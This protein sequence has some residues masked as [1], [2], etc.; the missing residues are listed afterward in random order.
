MPTERIGYRR[1]YDAIGCSLADCQEFEV[2]F[3]VG[4]DLGV[5]I[6]LGP[7]PKFGITVIRGDKYVV[8]GEQSLMLQAEIKKDATESSYPRRFF[9]ETLCWKDIEVREELSKAFRANEKD[10]HNELLRLAEREA[11]VFHAAVDLIAGTIGLRFHRQFVI[12]LINENFVTRRSDE[13]WPLRQ[14]GP[15][16]EMLEPIT[17]NPT[18]MQAVAE[19]LSAVGKAKQDAQKFGARVLHWLIRAWPER[20]T[21]SKFMFL[22]IPIE[23]ILEAHSGKVQEGATEQADAVRQLIG[24]H[25]GEK[26]SQLL[27]FFNSVMERQGPSLQARFEEM[28]SEA[29]LNGWQRDVKAF[30]LFNRVRND[31]LHRGDPEV[32]MLVSVGQ[33]E[34]RQLED[35]VERYVCY[36]LFR[37]ERVYQSRWRT[38]KGAPARGVE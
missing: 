1:L 21:I 12:E 5:R 32:K 23:I 14:T 33:E 29:Q 30:K 8:P 19:L 11:E 22:F 34:V 10:A 24:T 16:L 7:R 35:L 4:S 15:S 27:E 13:D 17:L 9:L 6:Y 2:E 3:T 20:D 31:L 38:K 36:V 37:D 28:A 18:G 26:Q 25:G